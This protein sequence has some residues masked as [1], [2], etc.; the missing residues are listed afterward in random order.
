V[1]ETSFKVSQVSEFQGDSLAIGGT[2]K[3]VPFYLLIE[4]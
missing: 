1:E 4:I 2:V 3:A